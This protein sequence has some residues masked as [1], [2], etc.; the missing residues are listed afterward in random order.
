[1]SYRM[2]ATDSETS[3]FVFWITDQPD[4][5][6][7]FY[8]GPGT[9]SGIVVAAVA[10]ELLNDLAVAHVPLYDKQAAD[11]AASTATAEHTIWR[12]DGKTKFTK[13]Y[14]DPDAALTHDATN[15]A[16]ILIQL[17]D[18]VGGAPSTVASLT[19]S[20][21]DWTAWETVDLGAITNLTNPPG[22]GAKLTLKI[23]KAAAGV[24]VPAM[25][26]F[27]VPSIS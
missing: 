12:F 18:G 5:A 13:L 26:V 8:P 15:N 11:G 3:T 22:A 16:T 10:D 6:G 24:A 1:M 21:A 19:T 4:L 27:G 23:T 20:A 7:A 14:I 9:P 2:M 17:R 25:K